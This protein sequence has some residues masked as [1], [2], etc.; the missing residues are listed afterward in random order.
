MPPPTVC[1]GFCAAFHGLAPKRRQRSCLQWRRR[2]GP[3]RGPAVA[4]AQGEAMSSPV[5]VPTSF[6]PPSLEVSHR[7]CGDGVCVVTPAGEIDLATAPALKSHL[8]GML[9]S[10]STRFVLDLSEVRYLDST[11]L[12]VL[13]AFGRR[14]PENGQITL[15]QLPD[16][17]RALL[18]LTGLD[19][20]FEVFATG[21]GALAHPR[22]ERPKVPPPLSSDAT[23]VIGLAATALP[24]AESTVDELRRWLRILSAHGEAGRALRCAGV[25]DTEPVVISAERLE[26]AGPAPH[27]GALSRVDAVAGMIAADREAASVSTVDL[28]LAVMTVYGDAFDLELHA[29][30]TSA[31]A[32]IDCLGSG[33]DTV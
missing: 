21:E 33:P 3:V 7:D 31:A 28:L 30:G 8:L 18:E 25:N 17:V 22:G 6:P 5:V 32:L 13:I 4:Q 26:A 14:L 20:S 16:P 11:G 29:R 9:E 2:A 15:A 12:G 1:R 23:I 19:A 24:F 27:A 10:G